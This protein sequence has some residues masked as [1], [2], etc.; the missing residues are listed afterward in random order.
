[1]VSQVQA[2]RCH[3]YKAVFN[4][5][6]ISA[7]GSIHGMTCR[8]YPVNGFATRWM[9]S[10]CL[11]IALSP[12]SLNTVRTTVLLLFPGISLWLVQYIG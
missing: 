5:V 6:K 10:G 2:Q 11:A 7:I 12:T 8:T 1:M 3:G 9:A 4:G